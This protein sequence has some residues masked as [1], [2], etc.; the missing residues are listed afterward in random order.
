MKGFLP[1]C[2]QSTVCSCLTLD[3]ETDLVVYSRVGVV[4][5]AGKGGYKF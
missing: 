2:G 4:D 3:T 1:F 5:A